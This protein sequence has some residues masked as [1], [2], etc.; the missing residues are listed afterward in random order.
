[1]VEVTQEELDRYG[2][3]GDIRNADETQ[4]IG[5]KKKKANKEEPVKRGK[6][7]NI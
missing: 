3:D 4:T 7:Q 2:E 1:M 6:N 5:K